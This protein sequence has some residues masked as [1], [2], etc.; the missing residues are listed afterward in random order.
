MMSEALAVHDQLLVDVVAGAGGSVFK[1][2]GD[3]I[4][5]VF[6]SPQRAVEAALAAQN[7]LALPVRIGLNT[8]EAEQ[9]DG[10]YFGPA[11]NRCARVMDAGHGGQILASAATKALVEEVEMRDLGE[12]RLKG[13]P[14]AQRIFQIGGGEFAALRLQESASL[15]TSRSSFVGRGDLVADVIARLDSDQVVTLVG[16]GGV[17]KT[18]TALA[19]AE[20]LA[21]GFERTVFVDL[22]L[23][24]DEADVLPT[25]ARALGV[26]NPT[27]EGVVMS[28]SSVD[29][30]FV[31]DN[32]EHVLDG[33]AEV[34]EAVLESS[35]TRVLATSR[36]ALVIEGEVLIPVT[37][38]EGDGL[39]SP[40]VRLFVDRA[41]SVSPG[42]ELDGD[43]GRIVRELCGRL[44]NLPL[45]IELAA[46]RVNAMSPAELLDRLDDRFS[47]LT[48]G[49]RRRRRDRYQTLRQAIDWSYDLLDREEQR[50]FARLAAFA[51]EFDLAGAAAVNTDLS[52]V[53]V[54]DV[55]SALVDKSLLTVVRSG[56]ST[57]YRY[58]ETVRSYAEELL[59]RSDDFDDVMLW[60]HD[61]L[62][63]FVASVIDDVWTPR[64]VD[65]LRRLRDQ[66]PNLRRALDTALARKDLAA[67]AELVAPRAQLLTFATQGFQ[68]W[69]DEILTLPGIEDDKS[70]QALM[71]ISAYEH[72]HAARWAQVRTAADQLL[73]SGDEDADPWWAFWIASFLTLMGGDRQEALRRAQRA[74]DTARD[75]G[76][77]Q[78][79]IAR[80][81]VALV[82]LTD[83]QPSDLTEAI[84]VD[85]ALGADHPSPLVSGFA[86]WCQA[87]LAYAHQ[88]HEG[89]VAIGQS[90]IEQAAEDD[91]NMLPALVYQGWGQL[92]LG[93]PVA[94]V[95][96][97]DSLLE[98][99]YRWGMPSEFLGAL[100]IYALAHQLVDD[101]RS[102][103]MVRGWLPS[104]FTFVFVDEI[105]AL[106][107]WLVEQLDS[108]E[109]RRLRHRGRGQTPRQLQHLTHQALEALEAAEGSL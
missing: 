46:A 97:A 54:L 87:M 62:A 76:S 58:L 29:S 43:S 81:G 106:D 80:L 17:G 55:L 90:I 88:D 15:P 39:D 93:Q 102:A 25:T 61:Y 52:D 96:T 67:A 51:G 23:A 49:R 98:F 85:L 104:R 92:G 38:L 5:A 63:T 73:V 91:H 45:A 31:F 47:M 78:E 69:A 1:H 26:P 7:A 8:G 24:S 14:A 4:C 9:R 108:E 84:Q 40:A 42:F 53:V 100:A 68:G 3:G 71:A 12:H 22:A 57:R 37:G 75:V 33:A 50:V 103:A 59:E 65:S 74:A 28:A 32:C 10:D 105:E 11:L 13:L 36:E 70:Y 99:G 19:A 56:S 79:L 16:V 83:P 101:P 41:R 60:F 34:I 95:S 66:I 86:R 82:L 18:R 6:S 109:L 27:V 89:M 30:L 77:D 35:R 20:R 94:A 48:G 21:P 107:Q 64:S 44:D 2:T 72:H